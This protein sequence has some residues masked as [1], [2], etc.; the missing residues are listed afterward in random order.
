MF[1]ALA[2]AVSST[3]GE[4]VK[5]T[6]DGVMVVFRHSAVDAVTC[7]VRMH[8]G[9]EALDP[10][11]PATIRV[12]IA[13][14]EVASE[15][16]DWFGTPVVEA[17][18]LESAASPGQTLVSAVVQSLVGTRGGHRFKPVGALT[19]KGLPSPVPAAAVLRG[20]SE[21]EPPPV[22]SPRRR[23]RFTAAMVGVALLV[24]AV[25]AASLIRDPSSSPADADAVPAAN[26][27]TPTYEARSC[28][29]DV[30]EAV[31]GATCG[32]LVVPEDR[33][34]PDN[35]HQV[36]LLVTRAPARGE[37]T[38][39]PVVDFGADTLASS[40]VREHAE[41]I[42]LSFRGAAPS[43]P[44]LTCPE[45]AAVAPAGL[46]RPLRDPLTISQGSA[47][48]A[49]CHARLQAA[50]IDTDHYSYEDTGADVLDLLRALHLDDVHLVSGYVATIGA[51]FVVRTAP[52]AIRSLTL[53]GP[54]VP[55]S[56]S[57]TDPTAHLA[58]AFDQYIELCEE[59]ASCAALGDLRVAYSE[60]HQS[61]ETSPATVVGDDG[62]GG[63]HDVFLDGDRLAQVIASSL[64][65]PDIHP[66][67]ASGIVL[68]RGPLLDSLSADRVIAHNFAAVVPDFP[69]GAHLGG[70]CSYDVHTIEPGHELSSQALPELSGVD[71]GELEWMCAA[72]P[73]DRLDD[74]AFDDGLA[75]DVPTLIV[76]G[77]ITPTGHVDW[78]RQ[79]ASRTVTHATV[80]TF[81]SLGHNAM[82]RDQPRCLDEIRQSFIAEPDAP[83][84]A[85]ACEAASPAIAFVDR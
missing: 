24:A 49:A 74:R 1:E 9:V 78:G 34:Q 22:R 50:G 16:G 42:Q 73:V 14:G 58:E 37:V 48:L 46:A 75:V 65:D 68:P 4:I 39:V 41:E 31:P 55:G 62:G 29:D 11:R 45:Y 25:I 70:R 8:D 6:G 18:R 80:L 60:G 64:F 81:P 3:G 38:S 21:P 10:E 12:G 61:Y 63:K 13:A 2:G 85:A 32:T 83:I 53:Q 17:S 52:S 7:S 72:W 76:Q 66:L 28:P 19:L 59:D 77:G 84:D 82:T 40:P 20:P 51:L 69:W 35:G 47:A 43:E 44:V 23:R 79:L 15:S 27:Y 26:G 30:Q 56:S 57:Y 67:L 71:D 33:T 36:R 5:N 54:V